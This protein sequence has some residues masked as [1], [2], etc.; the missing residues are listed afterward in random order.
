VIDSEAVC[1]DGSGVAIFVQLHGRA[2]DDLV[3]LYTFDLLELDTEDRRP[4]P[5]EE[6]K[7]KLKRL[8]AAAPAGIRYSEQ[9]DGDGATIF[10]DAYKLGLGGI[11]SKHRES[12]IED[13]ETPRLYAAGNAAPPM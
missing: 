5:L 6:R 12:P 9:L 13:Q 8:I 3:F 4:R 2:F 10:A 7:A 11:V 1:C